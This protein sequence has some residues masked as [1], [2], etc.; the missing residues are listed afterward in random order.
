MRRLIALFVMLSPVAALAQTNGPMPLA[1]DL[2]KAPLGAWSEYNVTSGPMPPVKM[3][4]ALVARQGK[5]HVLE[6]TMEGGM[7]AMMGGSMVSQ[8]TLA[9]D[10]TSTAKPVKKFVMQMGQKDPMEMPLDMPQLSVP[11]FQKPD[12]KQLVGKEEITVAA[13]KIKT[14]HYRQTVE[15]GTVDVW[16]AE[17]VYPIGLVKATSTPKPGAKGPNGQDMPPTTIELTKRGQGAKT[18]ITK[19]PKPFDPAMMGGG[20]PP[21]A[22]SPAA[23][24]AKK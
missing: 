16:V 8:L 23:S 2:K 3:K 15:Q 24:P 10:P 21:P 17:D 1:S 11:T 19:K 13:G 5:D 6:T 7:M 14:Q 4:A 12:P 22:A 18:T 9:A 20:A